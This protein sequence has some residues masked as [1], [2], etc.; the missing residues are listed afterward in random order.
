M[1]TLQRK[2]MRGIY[3][4]YALRLISL[5][6][7]L[8]G[9]VMLGALIVLTHFVSIGNV[10]QNLSHVEVGSIG[11]FAYN[12]VRTTEVWTLL[13]IGVLVFLSLSLRFSLVPKRKVDGYSFARI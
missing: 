4:A 8:Q 7:V 5:P 9:F 1:K 6:G 3:Y 2:I 12:A 13:L 10:I 11:T